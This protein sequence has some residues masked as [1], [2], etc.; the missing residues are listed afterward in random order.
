MAVETKIGNLQ[1]ELIADKTVCIIIGTAAF[2]ILTI[3][4]AYIRFSLPFTPVPITAQTFFVFLAGLFLGRRW[5]A[6]SQIGY[7]ILGLGG[8]AV[9]AGGGGLLYLAG[10]T[11]GYLLGFIACTWIIGRLIELIPL[12]KLS[13]RLGFAWV[14][15]SVFL[16]SLALYLL[17]IIQLMF[18]TKINFS[19]AVS[20]G[21][22]PFIPGY[23]IKM[24]SA[25]LL[26]WKFRYRIREIF[27]LQRN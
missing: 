1:R 23:I 25:S 24:F 16:G 6:V 3:L 2:T 11:G 22:F 12:D 26:F 7:L 5:S 14:V 8:L 27:P 18:L 4:G 15:F 13:N 21:V 17:G 9:F 20:L 10:P 19:K